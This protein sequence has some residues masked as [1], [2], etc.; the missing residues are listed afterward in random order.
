MKSISILLT[1]TLCTIVVDEVGGET[2]KGLISVSYDNVNETL[3][4]YM[5]QISEVNIK[6]K[7]E[8]DLIPRN[9][10][11]VKTKLKLI[12]RLPQFDILKLAP[13]NQTQWV[14]TRPIDLNFEV[15]NVLELNTLIRAEYLGRA[16]LKV[17]S[18]IVLDKNLTKT[19]L[20][21]TGIKPL[22][23]KVTQDEGIWGLIFIIAVSFLMIVIYINLGAQIDMDNVKQVLSRPKRMTTG[24]LISV[25]TMP[26]TSLLLFRLIVPD[27]TF[28]QI[29]SYVFACGPAALAS[30]PWTE[31]LGGDKE[32]SMGLQLLST[33]T[34]IITMPF[35]LHLMKLTL[36]DNNIL[37]DHSIKV[38]YRNLIGLSIVLLVSIL[39]GYRFIGLNPRLKKVSARIYRPLIFLILIAI[40]ISSSVIYWHLYRMFDW[41]LTLASA[42]VIVLSLSISSLAGL[43]ITCNERHALTIGISTI[44]KN[45]G[46]AFTVLLIAF[47][48]PENYVAYVPCLI[49]ILLTS[50]SFALVKI[51]LRIVKSLERRGQPDAVQA[52]TTDLDLEDGSDNRTKLR[53]DEDGNLNQ[54]CGINE[55]LKQTSQSDASTKTTEV[56]G[57]ETE[58]FVPIDVTSELENETKTE[59]KLRKSTDL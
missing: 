3:E 50:T 7:I 36:G 20:D 49:Q 33:I 38:P 12:T 1:I 16:E 47:R 40:I 30:T 19:P 5:G 39:I 13:W 27:Q 18:I 6:I 46:I 24:F 59:E 55:P 31:I 48:P 37:Q 52:T 43:L 35:L 25:T 58:A 42:L 34:S 56:E 14:Y 53:G 17:D 45:E 23:V 10:A 11:I 57:S 41:T 32:F 21:I 8:K 51:C 29:G 44:Y 26:I 2:E 9:G 28:H 22:Q 15:T 4:M 54:S